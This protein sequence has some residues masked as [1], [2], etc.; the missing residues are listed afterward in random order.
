MC[1]TR[2]LQFRAA[3]APLLLLLLSVAT[4]VALGCGE[5]E[6]S[7]LD[8]ADFSVVSAA[9]GHGGRSKRSTIDDRKACKP[10]DE[11]PVTR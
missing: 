8:A 11:Q 2:A 1:R 3:A 10:G 7:E 5:S 4:D 6:Y 9:G